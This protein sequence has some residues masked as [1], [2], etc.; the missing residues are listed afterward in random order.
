MSVCEAARQAALARHN[1][2]M[3][4]RNRRAVEADVTE[5]EIERDVN[6]I[7]ALGEFVEVPLM[8]VLSLS[9]DRDDDFVVHLACTGN[10]DYQCTLD[11]HLRTRPVIDFCQASG[12]TIVADAELLAVLRRHP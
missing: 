4:E 6:E 7:R 1:R 5:E 10:A 3:D 12:I 11:R 9:T 2:I 8:D